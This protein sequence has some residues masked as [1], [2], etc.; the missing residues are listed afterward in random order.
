MFLV[1]RD[2]LSVQTGA[3]GR[4]KIL[5]DVIVALQG[6]LRVMTRDRGVVD[7]NG[8]VRDAPDRN[9]ILRQFLRNVGTVRERDLELG[10]AR[11]AIKAQRFS[12]MSLA[13]CWKK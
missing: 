5:E 11:E 4:A 6:Q 9:D 1:G 12:S 10:H 8:V 3:V 7:L 13:N 2:V